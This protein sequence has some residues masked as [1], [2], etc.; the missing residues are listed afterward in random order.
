MFRSVLAI[1]FLFLVTPRLLKLNLRMPLL[2]GFAAYAAG[3]A[4]LVFT[5]AEGFIRYVILC[6]SLIFDGFG[7][8]TLAML[9]E[10]L[11]ALHVD[12]AE[13]ARVM[14]IQH[15]I[16]MFATMPFGW[17]GGI[18]SGINRAY[19]FMLTIALLAAGIVVTLFYYHRNPQEARVGHENESM[20]IEEE[21]S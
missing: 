17:I 8:G 12:K 21:K 1:A 7:L 13:R 19:P 16:I 18:L 4:I 9:A 3:Q 6:I 10:S 20:S 5:P 2:F 15:M 11:V 14:A